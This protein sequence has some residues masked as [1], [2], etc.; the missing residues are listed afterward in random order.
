[1]HSKNCI[2]SQCIFFYLQC[3][4]YCC[5][6]GEKYSSYTTRLLSRSF[7]LQDSQNKPNCNN[8]TVG[9]PWHPAMEQFPSPRKR[10]AAWLHSWHAPNTVFLHFGS[11]RLSLARQTRLQWRCHWHLSKKAQLA[12][13]ATWQTSKHMQ[14]SPSTIP[15]GKDQKGSKRLS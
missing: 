7:L 6:W 15:Q 1:M 4:P 14:D 5:M 12:D 8:Q 2:Y 9:A 11:T 3:F 10:L 13:R